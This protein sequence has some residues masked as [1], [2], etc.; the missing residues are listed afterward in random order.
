MSPAGLCRST[1]DDRNKSVGHRSASVL[2]LVYW[3]RSIRPIILFQ[4]YT[5]AYS[6]RHYLPRAF[7]ICMDVS[8][9]VVACG[10]LLAILVTAVIPDVTSIDFLWNNINPVWVCV[11]VC[12]TISFSR[13]SL[14]RVWLPI[15]VVVSRVRFGRPVPRQ[16]SLSPRQGWIWCL[17][18]VLHSPLPLSATISFRSAMRHRTSLEF[19]RP[20]TCAGAG[21]VVLKVSQQIN[22]RTSFP[23]P[24]T[25]TVNMHLSQKQFW[26][27]FCSSPCAEQAGVRVF[28]SAWCPFI[29]LHLDVLA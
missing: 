28:G 11:C 22:V 29:S 20:R 5:I 21:P 10:R 7:K 26:L 4:K 25:G 18:Q 3:L 12:V 1:T 6:L 2:E 27:C 13:L 17:N 9:R 23:M 19:I 15:L 14:N 24:S 16:S 8:T